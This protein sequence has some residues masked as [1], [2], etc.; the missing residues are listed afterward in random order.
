[1]KKI[2]VLL[3]MLSIN[4]LN[5]FARQMP[6]FSG[7]TADKKRIAIPSHCKGKYALICFVMSKKAQKDLE[8]WL[9]PVYYHYIAKAGFMDDMFEV[10]VFLVPVLSGAEAGMTESIKRKFMENAQKELWPHVLFSKDDLKTV[11]STLGVKRDDVSYLFLLDKNGQVIHETSG[12][13]SEEKFDAIDDLI[14]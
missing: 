4:I 2:L 7:E 13:Y 1:M 14:E 9:E 8:S 3:L 11:T 10:D 6:S 12:A 5:V